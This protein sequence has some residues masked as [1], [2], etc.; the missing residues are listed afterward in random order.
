MKKNLKTTRIFP[1]FCNQFR[2][3]T[4]IKPIHL[5]A[6]FC[7]SNFFPLPLPISWRDDNDMWSHLQS[8]RLSTRS[9]LLELR[10][11]VREK[12][13]GQGTHR[14][15]MDFARVQQSQVRRDVIYWILLVT[16]VVRRPVAV[17]YLVKTT[18]ST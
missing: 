1:N 2:V 6:P 8:H 4:I 18:N 9:F 17:P 12:L 5:L 10:F 14:A 15:E 13:S 11:Q 3:K 16:P 7:F